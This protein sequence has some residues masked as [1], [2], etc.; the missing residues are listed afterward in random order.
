MLGTRLRPAS[1]GSSEFGFRTAIDRRVIGEID[2]VEKSST[3]V[4]D[5]VR[6]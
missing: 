3:V 4:S 6:V 2:R 5:H 1:L